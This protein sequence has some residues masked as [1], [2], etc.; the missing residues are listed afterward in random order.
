MTTNLFQE[1]SVPVMFGKVSYVLKLYVLR[2]LWLLIDDPKIT[3][4]RTIA[5]EL[6]FQ[7]FLL[8]VVWWYLAA[9]LP[10]QPKFESTDI[11]CACI[12]ISMQCIEG[13][14]SWVL[15]ACLVLSQ[16]GSA[17]E[18]QADSVH[19]EFLTQVVAECI[20][21]THVLRRSCLR[22]IQTSSVLT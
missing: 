20:P 15:I 22:R 12:Q 16:A 8:I 21:Q 17:R 6:L 5:K 19:K 13:S 11:L 9:N 14:V 1:M 4:I 10:P 7:C 2:Y 18:T 3:M